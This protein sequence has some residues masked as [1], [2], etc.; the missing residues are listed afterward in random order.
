[1]QVVMG[2]IIGAQG[3]LP[4]TVFSV[5]VMFVDLVAGCVAFQLDP[6]AMGDAIVHFDR[7]REKGLRIAL[8]RLALIAIVHIEHDDSGVEKA[9]RLHRPFGRRR[10]ARE[11][12]GQH[13]G[14]PQRSKLFRML[15]DV[16]L[17]LL[18]QVRGR[19]L[20]TTPAMVVAGISFHTR[21]STG[22]GGGSDKLPN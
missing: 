1:M 7:R 19:T 10:R 15:H 4:K 13:Q 5:K 11:A 17:L 6:R 14:A 21:G 16:L 22:Y 12:G 20:S 3:D 2:G 18:K 9:G 8:N